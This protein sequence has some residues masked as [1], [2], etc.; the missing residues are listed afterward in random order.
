[1]PQRDRRRL[2]LC[3][4]LW[5]AGEGLFLY[6]FPLYIRALGGGPTVVGLVLAVQAALAG[7]STALAGP[8][9]DRVGR[10]PLIRIT[11]L[12]ATPGVIIWAVAPHWEWIIPGTLLFGLSFAGFPAFNA[13]VSAGH[14]DQVGVFGS[15]FAFF[16]L[17]MIATPGLG[18]LIATQFH[19][20]RP[21]F[22]LTA[23]LWI[24]SVVAVWGISPQP[25]E[26]HEPLLTA[27]RGVGGNRRLLAL[28][29]YI[30]ALL[31]VMSMTN[32]YVGPY[33]QDVDGASDATVGLLGGFISLGEFLL[34]LALG[35]INERVGRVLTLLA[36]QT[37]MALS[38]L[39]LLTIHVVPAL[40]F[41]FVL[42]GAILTCMTMG[43]ALV[44]G[45]LPPRQQGAGYGLMGMSTQIGMMI[46][47]YAGGLFYASGATHPFIASLALLGVM[48][49][50][51]VLLAPLLAGRLV[52]AVPEAQA[53]R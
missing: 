4:F 52:Q 16:S 6:L 45:V 3:L 10:R 39:M 25:I 36:L 13:Y 46:A 47:A 48:A 43:M 7:V 24:A 37:I 41:A 5:G 2:K 19:S 33:L 9:A 22:A 32:S 49:V 23:V 53:A 50:T 27:L 12:I 51:T 15:T 35:R 8:L 1:M 11:T 40:V 31:F 21:V 30:V 26:P 44:G 14:D 42:R 17:G 34:G 38:L 18:G 29:A 28:C 20:I